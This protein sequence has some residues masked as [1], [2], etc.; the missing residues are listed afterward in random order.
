M[1]LNGVNGG[2]EGVITSSADM[3]V[4]APAGTVDMPFLQPVPNSLLCSVVFRDVILNYSEAEPRPELSA[5]LKSC[6]CY[7]FL[8]G[9]NEYISYGLAQK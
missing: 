8:L 5:Q 1:C 7:F 6:L 2:L 4:R 9:K 3:D